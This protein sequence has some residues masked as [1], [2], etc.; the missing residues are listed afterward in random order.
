MPGDLVPSA[1]EYSMASYLQLR[2][3]KR[4]LMWIGHHLHWDV[5]ISYSV[6]GQHVDAVRELVPQGVGVPVAEVFDLLWIDSQRSGFSGDI[7]RGFAVTESLE[8]PV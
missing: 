8:V 3:E 2:S 5:C 6:N 1:L 4:E 7:G